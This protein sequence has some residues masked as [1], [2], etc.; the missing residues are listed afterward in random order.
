MESGYLSSTP[1]SPYSALQ[2]FAEYAHRGL[3]MTAGL[4]ILG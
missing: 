1:K 4:P 2:I 3:A